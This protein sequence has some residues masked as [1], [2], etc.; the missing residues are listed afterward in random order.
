MNAKLQL[1][2]EKILMLNASLN[3][4]NKET[5]ITKSKL[6]SEPKNVYLYDAK[7]NSI[8]NEFNEKNIELQMKFDNLLSQIEGYK[9]LLQ[10]NF[11]EDD[12]NT[13]TSIDNIKTLCSDL[14]K[15]Q[16]NNQL[17]IEEDSNQIVLETQSKMLSLHN[18]NNSQNK[19]NEN[20]IEILEKNVK[21][22]FTDK[23]VPSFSTNKFDTLNQL[24]T[25]PTEICDMFKSLNVEK[26]KDNVAE[27]NSKN[28]KIVDSIR[29]INC[30]VDTF[31]EGE[32]KKRNEFNNAI[33]GLLEETMNSL[34]NNKSNQDNK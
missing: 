34:S 32:N 19:D 20:D 25:I 22:I 16:T 17:Q 10:D 23:I 3:Y 28:K 12:I 14:C 27:S 4:N 26:E 13:K 24:D 21:E 15:E 6:S 29:G 31:I 9:K 5:P 7:I 2:Q 18:D 30:K 1:L 33:F 8:K 11:T